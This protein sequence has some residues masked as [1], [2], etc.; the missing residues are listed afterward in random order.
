MNLPEKSTQLEKRSEDS[1]CHGQFIQ[2]THVLRLVDGE[3]GVTL[4]V[5]DHLG[6]LQHLELLQQLETNGEEGE[7]DGEHI[8]HVPSLLEELLGAQLLEHAETVDDVVEGGQAE[9]NLTGQGHYTPDTGHVPGEKSFVLCQP[10]RSKNNIL[11]TNQKQES[12]CVN[13]SEVSNYLVR[14]ITSTL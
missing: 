8:H 4:G 12:Y 6:Q 7:K 3:V 5:G 10:I 1:H 13:Q 2:I 11:S 14:E 9:C